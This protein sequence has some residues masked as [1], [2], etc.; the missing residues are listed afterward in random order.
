MNMTRTRQLGIA[1]AL[2]PTLC[3]LLLP[4][5]FLLCLWLRPSPARAQFTP[6]SISKAYGINLIGANY[7]GAGQTIAIIDA[8]GAVGTG[9]QSNLYNDVNQFNTQYLPAN[10]PALSLTVLNQ[11]GH[12]AASSLPAYN[13]AWAEETTLDVEYAHAIAPGAK[14][15]VVEASS[16]GYSDL[17][18]AASYAAS[19][20]ASVVSMSFY[21][22]EDTSNDN[23]FNTDTGPGSPS[24][25]AGQPGVGQKRV[26]FIAS[27]GD[28]GSSGG[29]GYPA[30]NPYVIGVGGTTLAV[31]MDGSY[32]GETAWS[33]S[34]GGVS[35]SENRP[36]Y[37]DGVQS[38]AFRT[39]PDVSFDANPS[40]GVNIVF[41][42][43]T[44][45]VGGTSI[46]APAWAGLFALAD[47]IRV[48]NGLPVLSSLDALEAM[49]ATYG[50]AAYSAAFHDIVGGNNGGYTATSGYDDVTGLGSPVADYLV[51]YLGSFPVPEPVGAAVILMGLPMLLRRRREPG[52]Q[53]AITG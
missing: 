29:V 11:T 45:T 34:G 16:N 31:N 25:N 42:G 48:A 43:T 17:F 53:R 30:S 13:A 2:T 36:S 49:Y 6:T 38:S 47:Q 12:S 1:C 51:P 3:K 35:T 8:Y 18:T 32:S 41:N 50:T 7:T 15:Q 27:T 52:R 46:G 24:Y 5:C 28:S 20:G 23:T 19:H 9:S 4:A 21:G 37:Q 40:S 14:I 10:A 33:G 26:A 39:E 22:G 44:L